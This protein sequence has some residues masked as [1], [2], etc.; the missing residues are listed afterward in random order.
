MECLGF[1]S[2]VA[3]PQGPV[4]KG[5]PVLQGRYNQLYS[6]LRTSNVRIIESEERRRL[7]RACL[8]DQA[9][10]RWSRVASTANWIL[11][12]LLTYKEP[13]SKKS[14]PLSEKSGVWDT[15]G[16]NSG[17]PP[18]AFPAVS[19][20]SRPEA[21]T[22]SAATRRIHRYAVGHTKPL[23]LETVEVC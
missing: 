14:E 21:P 3:I 6:L 1:Q 20:G 2:L 18:A 5:S 12:S 23:A 8:L 19:V 10:L 11:S 13:S 16:A 7:R 9:S 17:H 22:D 4:V 15:L